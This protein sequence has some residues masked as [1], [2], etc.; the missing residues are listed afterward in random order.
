MILKNNFK[1]RS[2]A[3]LQVVFIMIALGCKSNTG[4]MGGKRDG[5]NSQ[6]EDLKVGDQ[7][8]GDGSRQGQENHAAED[9]SASTPVNIL[10]TFLACRVHKEPTSTDLQSQLGCLVVDEA[11]K[12]KAN[13]G[14]KVALAGWE[15]TSAQVSDGVSVTVSALDPSE[16]FHVIYTLKGPSVDTI[17]RHRD[18]AVVTLKDKEKDQPVATNSVKSLVTVPLPEEVVN[19]I[20]NITFTPPE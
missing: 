17:K 16:A 20:E 4:F 8:K 1:Y 2:F 9:E 3:F 10:G 11:T 6:D 5:S 19:N 14:G 15:L 7:Q 13:L 12:K 18:S